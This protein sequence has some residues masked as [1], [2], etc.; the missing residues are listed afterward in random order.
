MNV[1]GAFFKKQVVL[2]N[3]PTVVYDVD[4]S[5]GA[6]ININISSLNIMSNSRIQVFITDT[7]ERDLSGKYMDVILGLDNSILA[8]ERTRIQLPV[9]LKVIVVAS[10]DS[11][12][13]IY[14]QKGIIDGN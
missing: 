11:P 3:I 5:I 8:I 2:A 4:Y 13:Q 10:L 6:T 12:V 9:G 1:M 7:D 14:G